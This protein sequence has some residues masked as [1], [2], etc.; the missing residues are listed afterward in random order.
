MF[1]PVD[2]KESSSAK[3]SKDNEE[4]KCDDICL[5]YVW[6]Y[7]KQKGKLYKKVML[8]AVSAEALPSGAVVVI[9]PSCF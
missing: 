1:F 4:D 3:A 2:K 6:K 5:F 8:R 9:V 7:C